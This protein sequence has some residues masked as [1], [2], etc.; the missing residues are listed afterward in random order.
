MSET[1][2]KEENLSN[3]E[4]D[5][6]VMLDMD[7]GDADGQDQAE[8]Q[9]QEVSVFE[10][11]EIVSG[12]VSFDKDI[13]ILAL[14]PLPER[15]IG[16]VKAYRAVGRNRN[17]DDYF[18]LVCERSL[19]PRIKA[20]VAYDRIEHSSL[21]KL[22]DFGVLYWPEARQERYVFI[23]K[24]TM[25]S[26]LLKRG[27]DN[28]LKWKQD[29]VMD[30]I[31]K[32]MIGMLQEF[33]DRDFFH[34]A[35]CPENIFN[36]DK[37]DNIKSVVLGDCLSAPAS[38][39]QSVLYETIERSLIE[40]IAR[41]V[42]TPSDDLYA[43]GVSLAVV[44]RSNDPLEGLDD[45]EIIKRKI[46]YGTYSAITGK[47]RFKGLILE[48][49]RGILHDNPTQ[50][51][52]IDEVLIWMDGRRLSPKQSQKQRKAP[53]PF[54]FIDQKY[55]LIQ[56]LAM[57]IGKH[58]D[59]TLKIIEN[60][61]LVQ[62][63]ERSVEDEDV[64]LQVQEA[65]EFAREGGAVSDYHNRLSA[66]VAL[67][68]YPMSPIYY[69][70]R[71]FNGDGI[72]T[73]L[74]EAI[75]LRRDT[76]VFSELFRN[77]IAIRWLAATQNPGLDVSILLNK[78]DACRTFLLQSRVG[79]GIERCLYFLCPEAHCLSEKL[80][81]YFV[82]TPE[83]MIDAFEDMC[84]RGESPAFFLDR[85]TV[86]FL[87]LKDPRCIDAYLY[88]LGSSEEYRKILGNLKVLARIQGRRKLKQFPNIA[89]AFVEMLPVVYD[90]YHDN[91]SR[92]KIEKNVNNCAS[93]GDLVGMA[94]L[95]NNTDTQ[96]KDITSFKQAMYE[97]STLKKEW[98]DLEERLKDKAT[99]GYGI[100]S[101]ISAI[102]S[103]ILSGVII[104]CI[105]FY[106]IL[107]QTGF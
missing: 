88:D 76:K 29:A 86:A 33:R 26:P 6:E 71:R 79:F 106:F 59:E 16:S 13:D 32:P 12:A 102:I 60:D 34:G 95:L 49:L 27:E 21:I 67:A 18:A 78:F 28:F 43:F 70:G 82:T 74:A 72:G 36:A 84:K 93:S 39:F 104:L 87:S 101:E 98:N 41:G 100:G 54:V 15:D 66:G 73:S 61:E 107:G 35:I 11:T 85:H 25:G 69:K 20:A 81:R 7:A 91:K 31:V 64:S 3:K 68:L 40:P 96:Q 45:L 51:W 1:P 37:F 9:E 14:D 17:T 47:D 53:R 48:L 23:Y 10:E 52:T 90:R 97:Y 24:D 30:I 56:I 44:M 62:W 89:K 83:Q 75:V 19:V 8:E 42:G 105:A 55:F 80:K 58:P 77:N 2:Q 4:D 50:R 57:D 5:Q 22:V 94:G 63:L 99:F 46:E 92:V 103:S 38:Y 65:R